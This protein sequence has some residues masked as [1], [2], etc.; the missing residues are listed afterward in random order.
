MAPLPVFT[1]AADDLTWHYFL[2]LAAVA[3]LTSIGVFFI[4]RRI[5]Q[6]IAYL[7]HAADRISLGELDTRIDMDRKDE[8]GE[9]AEAIVRLQASIKVAME[10]FR[11]RRGN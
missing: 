1:K 4:S 6:P 10:R 3:G 7:T 8:I 2:I 9:L 5:T 11:A